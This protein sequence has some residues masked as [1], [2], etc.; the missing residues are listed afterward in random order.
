MQSLK[1]IFYFNIKEDFYFSNEYV[2][3]ETDMKKDWQIFGI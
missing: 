3:S 1:N 2:S